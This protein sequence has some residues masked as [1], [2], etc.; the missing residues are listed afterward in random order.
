M[1]VADEVARGSN[2]GTNKLMTFMQDLRVRVAFW[3]VI[4][5]IYQAME[6]PVRKR[7][8]RARVYDGR[9]SRRRRG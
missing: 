9:G 1:G 3:F 8:L 7:R 2:G 4:V 6:Y 5:L